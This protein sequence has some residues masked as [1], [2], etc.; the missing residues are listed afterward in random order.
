M[1]KFL[2]GLVDKTNYITTENGAIAHRTTKS[3]LLDMFALGGS[4]RNRSDED[5]ILMFKKAYAENPLYA[6][7]C[8]FYLRDCRGGA[9][10]RRFFRI[11]IK[12]LAINMPEVIE[13]NIENIPFFGRYDDLY[14]LEG[15]PVE[16]KMFEFI[17]KQLAI[18]IQCKIPSLLAKWLKSENCSS[19][20]SRRLGNKTRL[21]LGMNHKQ[22]RKTLSILREK[23]NIVE[24]LMS[25]GK[26]NQIKYD[27][28]P[29]K[30]GL[31]YKNAFAKHDYD[32]YKAFSESKTTKVNAATLNPVD[33]A[34]QIFQYGSWYGTSASDIE[35]AMWQK[36]WDNLKDY[37]NGREER[38]IAVVDVSGSMSGTPMNA[39]VS[40]GAY[41]AE[42]GKGPFANHFITFSSHPELVKFDGIDIY[43]KFQRA[44]N[45]NWGGSTNIEAT[46]DLLLKTALDNNCTQ[47]EIPETVYVFS[48]MEFNDCVSENKSR[49]SW[50]GSIT[51]DEAETL[52][53]TMRKKWNSYGYKM[54]RL[55]FWN[56]DARQNNIP[57]IG[58][59]ISYVSGFSMAALEGVLSGKDGIDMMMEILNK[60]RYSIIK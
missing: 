14:A 30:A 40:M 49:Y 1:N 7:K 20:E 42:R 55:I 37:Y 45:A 9:G 5:V 6:L 36:Y 11:C 59:S 17:K 27:K 56:L 13:R 46:F 21:A 31:I 50:G 12:D 34:G 33:I 38:G 18:D 4:M 47:E 32:R 41:I 44:S 22:Y 60:E 25:E 19:K 10:E 39:A 53:D 28:I 8:L 23:I 54:P 58:D 26:W 15:T 52:F 57:A 51:L 16:K 29:S 3:D 43:D 24:R 35:R 48:D 2:N